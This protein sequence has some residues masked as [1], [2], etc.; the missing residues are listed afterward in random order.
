MDVSVLTAAQVQAAAGYPDPEA[1]VLLNSQG[2]ATALRDCPDITP[3]QKKGAE[4]RYV[5]R[6]SAVQ[7]L[8]KS[9]G[10]EGA[11]VQINRLLLM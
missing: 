2:V 7:E 8:V 3:Y 9:L 4:P 10:V 11:T 5:C 1:V 6:V